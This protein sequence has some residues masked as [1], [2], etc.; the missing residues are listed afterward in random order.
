MGPFIFKMFFL[1]M[2]SSCINSTKGWSVSDLIK[3]FPSTITSN[4]IVDPND[5]INK[6]S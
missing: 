4:L 2:I 3:E 1:S 6:Q 5:Y